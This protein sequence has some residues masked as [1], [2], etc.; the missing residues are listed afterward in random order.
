MRVYFGKKLI[1]IETNVDWALPYW[2]KR[3]A[4]DDRIR[5][6]FV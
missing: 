5:W 4:L 3:K 2:T 1:V 6:E